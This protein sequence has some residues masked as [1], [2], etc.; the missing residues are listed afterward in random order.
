MLWQVITKRDTMNPKM[1]KKLPS[2]SMEQISIS[3]T[4]P[5]NGKIAEDSRFT[6]SFSCLDREHPLFNLGDSKGPISSGWFLDLIDCL[7]SVNNM[8][9]NELR[10]SMY[11][12]HPVNWKNTNTA[13]PKNTEQ[14][15]YWQFRISKNKGRIIGFYI[16]NVFYIVW[17]D[18][19]HNLTDSEGYG[20]AVRYNRPKSEY[21]KLLDS[22]KKL[23]KQNSELAEAVKIYE[24]TCMDCKKSKK[25]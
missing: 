18:S 22:N 14:L 1:T 21:E 25:D 9:F 12:L 15:E 23:K 4:L 6:F 24:D 3:K 19:N 11:D 8:K 5:N 7:K 10:Q 20:K 17:L 13:C 2:P 16:D